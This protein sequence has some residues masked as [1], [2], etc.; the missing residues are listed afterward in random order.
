[1][2]SGYR[3]LLSSCILTAVLAAPT[4]IRAAKPQDN[5]RQEE[6]HRDDKNQ[7]RVYDRSH[8]E[9]HNWDAN[10]DH[11]YRQYL[12]DKHKKYRPFTETKPKEQTAYWNW[13]HSHPDHNGD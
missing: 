13:R 7:N 4:A 1:M 3:Y 2:H 5:G 6:N 11:S 8:T 10:E 12:G 9:D